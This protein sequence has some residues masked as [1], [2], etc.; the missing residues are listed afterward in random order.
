MDSERFKQPLPPRSLPYFPGQLSALR[1]VLRPCASP[2]V[3]PPTGLS[4]SAAPRAFPEPAP[5]KYLWAEPRFAQPG[6]WDPAPPGLRPC[7]TSVGPAA[8]SRPTA[9]RLPRRPGRAG[10]GPVGRVSSPSER[11][12]AGANNVTP[13]LPLLS[14][15]LPNSR[16]RTLLP[17]GEVPAGGSWAGL[18]AG[19]WVPRA[20]SPAPAWPPSPGREATSPAAEWKP[21]QQVT[22]RW[23]VTVISQ[24]MRCRSPGHSKIISSNHPPPR[25]SHQHSPPRANKA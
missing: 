19:C 23:V 6:L 7:S 11:A 15:K 13:S 24:R 25:P 17:G 22:N 5:S 9:S 8:R 3:R 1:F 4:A 20:R 21:V 16:W 12:S 14:P 10:Q 2:L 18:A